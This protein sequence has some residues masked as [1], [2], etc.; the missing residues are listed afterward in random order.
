M[1]LMYPTIRNQEP[2]LASVRVTRSCVGSVSEISAAFADNRPQA[3]VITVRKQWGMGVMG[4]ALV[5][6]PGNSPIR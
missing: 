2:T 3:G 1:N 6:G 4:L 5:S